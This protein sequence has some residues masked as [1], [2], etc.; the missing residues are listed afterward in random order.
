MTVKTAGKPPHKAANFINNKEKC[1]EDTIINGVSLNDLKAKKQ[2]IRKDAVVF[3]SDAIDKVKVLVGKLA[4]ATTQGEVDELS[5]S[6]YGTL[7]NANVVA[8]IAD[9]PYLLP[10]YEE[11]GGYDSSEILSDVIVESDNELLAFKYSENT[12]IAKLASLLYSME[13]ESKNWHSSTC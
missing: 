7:D 3:V 6:A 9:I 1:M 13:S 2:A 5:K 4:E 11:Y 10:Y 12:Y 8:G